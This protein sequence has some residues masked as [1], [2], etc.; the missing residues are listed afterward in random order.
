MGLWE[1]FVECGIRVATFFIKT[2]VRML[3]LLNTRVLDHN[4]NVLKSDVSTETLN[5]LQVKEDLEI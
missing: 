1:L 5:K 3:R 4:N 2:L